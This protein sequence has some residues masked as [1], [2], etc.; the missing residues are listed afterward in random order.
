MDPF[1]VLGLEET[2]DDATVRTAYLQAL[3]SAPPDRDPEGFRRIRAAYEA[4][5]DAESRLDLRL[6]GPAPLDDLATLLEVF[7]EERRHVGPDLWL[8][9]LREARR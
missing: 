7:P 3:R 6:F 4:L 8:A 5:R 9:V 1:A 2:A